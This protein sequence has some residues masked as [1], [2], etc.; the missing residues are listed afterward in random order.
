MKLSPTLP[1]HTVT[2]LNTTINIESVVLNKGQCFNHQGHTWFNEMLDFSLESPESAKT[3]PFLFYWQS[4]SLL[5]QIVCLLKWNAPTIAQ[6]GFYNQFTYWKWVRGVELTSEMW[7]VMYLST[8][9]PNFSNTLYLF[10]TSFQKELFFSSH[11]EVLS[12]LYWN[13]C[14]VHC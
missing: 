13:N 3:N 4:S 11:Y 8:K 12:L 6:K 5:L 2:E 9:R 14:S 10:S 7:S 1:D